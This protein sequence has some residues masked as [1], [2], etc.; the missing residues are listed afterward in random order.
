MPAAIMSWVAPT[1]ALCPERPCTTL[2]GTPARA[3]I[4]LMIRGTWLGS[5][6]SPRPSPLPT[7]RNSRP[8]EIPALQMPRA[9]QPHGVPRGVDDLAQPLGVGLRAAH[10]KGRVARDFFRKIGDLQGSKLRAAQH[11][12][13]GDGKQRAVPDIDQ[14]LPRACQQALPQWPGEPLHLLLAAALRPAHALEGELNRRTLERL[15]RS[16][17]PVRHRDAGDLAAHRSWLP[18][19]RHRIDERRDGLRARRQRLPYPLQVPL[20]MDA[21][22][23]ADGPLDHQE[24]TVHNGHAIGVDRNDRQVAD[25]DGEIHRMPGLERLNARVR[26]HKRALS[27]KK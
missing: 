10:D 17:R 24:H 22:I 2:S 14:L 1:R 16:D 5:R 25:S 27:R 12:V 13:V 15:A 9:H 19:L 6:R 8:P 26:R 21:E 23:G 3:A 11:R 7:E 20:G 18:R 4:A